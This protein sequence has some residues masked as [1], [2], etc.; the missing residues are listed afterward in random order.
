MTASGAVRGGFAHSPCL[1]MMRSTSSKEGA[2][3][4]GLEDWNPLLT[5]GGDSKSM[6]G[7]ISVIAMPLDVVRRNKRWL[8]MYASCKWPN[9]ACYVT[10]LFVNIEQ[11][12]F[13]RVF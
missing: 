12:Q 1:H 4:R 7:R 10:N 13:Y 3:T 5:K 8:A 11:K 2:N 9:A 6:A